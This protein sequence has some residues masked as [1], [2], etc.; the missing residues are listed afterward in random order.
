MMK[1]ESELRQMFAPIA[2]WA[3][4]VNQQVL[5]WSLIAIAV[6]ILL[7]GPL[8]RGIMWVNIRILRT[9]SI[10]VAEPVQRDVETG[11][12]VVV[13]CTAALLAFHAIEPPLLISGIIE[14]LIL[15]VIVIAVFA[16]WYNRAGPLISLLNPEQLTK[17]MTEMDWAV[18]V[19]RFVII[20]LAITALLQLWN[21]D[22]SA[23]ITGVGVLG[24]GLA[25]AAQDMLKNLF[26]GMSNV[27]ERRFV[28][29]DWIQVEGIAE[30]MVQ[31]IDLRSTTILGFDRV[32]RY[33]PNA[34]LANATVQNLSRRDYRRVNWTV[35]LVLSSTTEQLD[36][37]CAGIRDYL[38]TSGD[39]ITTGEVLCL[40]HVVGISASAV[41][42]KIYAFADA[43]G[44]EDFLKT[45]ERLTAC[46]MHTVH[47]HGTELAYPTRSL[48]VEDRVRPQ[49]PEAGQT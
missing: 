33:V 31:Q 29:G 37:V 7:R 41:D 44:Y 2:E 3:I 48:F 24:A 6:A 21:I 30:G 32:P 27:S 49:P 46:V 12:R 19:A 10:E 16:V 22:V 26:G 5:M 18:R 28:T 34:D 38:Q 14:K 45:C 39:F 15:T 13:V 11:L 4:S 9:M 36:A 35:P 8:A 40:A 1:T 25:I 47:A 23:A 43:A 17:L 20:L 42:V